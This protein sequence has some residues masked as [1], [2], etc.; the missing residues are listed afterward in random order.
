MK[1]YISFF[2]LVCC[3]A[4]YLNAQSHGVLSVGPMV[5]IKGDGVSLE[6]IPQGKK[7]GANFNTNP[8][9]GILFQGRF[10]AGQSLNGGFGL[11]ISYRNTM[12]V[13][14][15]VANDSNTTQRFFG[16]GKENVETIGTV[17]MLAVSPSIFIGMFQ[18]GMH[19]NF[20][21]NTKFKVLEYNNGTKTFPEQELETAGTD[22]ISTIIEP[23][24]GLQ[25]PAVTTDFGSF[26]ILLNASIQMG[27][28]TI[29]SK[30]PTGEF[31]INRL[32]NSELSMTGYVPTVSLGLNYQ[33]N[34]FKFAY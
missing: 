26:N 31:D 21:L 29:K 5:S 6:T 19:I 25:I 14:N 24:V 7:T 11:G 27:A 34:V 17:Q 9:F 23:F 20:P 15:Y 10:T 16:V 33:F 12:L 13:D 3:T 18:I 32:V 22:G 4:T 1:N 28:Y 8:D 2:V 30:A